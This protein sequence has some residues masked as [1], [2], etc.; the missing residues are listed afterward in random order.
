MRAI[1]RSI[2]KIF[3][4]ILTI[5]TVIITALSLSSCKTLGE[6]VIASSDTFE[7]TR[8]DII[9][10][11]STSG[12][13]D[14]SEKNDYSIAT[15]GKVLHALEKG[16]IFNKGDVLLEI[17]NS[18]QKL[19]IAQAEENL[20]AARNSFS[21]AQI[22]YQRALDANHIAIQLAET[23]SQQA[24]L[25]TISALKALEN[26]NNM[27]DKSEKSAKVAL[28]NAKKLLNE[29]KDEPL[30][31]DT[32]LAQYEANVD[33]AEANYDSV[34]AQGRSTAESAKNAYEQSILGQSA[35]YWSNL[36]STQS[37]KSQVEAT[38]VNIK[39]AETQINLSEISLE[40]ARLDVD[41]NIIYAPYNGIVLSS[42]YKEGQYASP[43]MNAISIISNDFIIKADINEADIVNLKVGQDVDIILDAYP[44]I[45]FKGKIIE[46]SRIPTSIGGVVSFDF[47]VRP[48]KENA[49]E[50]LYGLSASLE[51]IELVSENI[52]YVP[53]DSIIEEDG[54]TYVNLVTEDGKVKKTEVVTGAFNYEFI[55]IKSGLSEG[56]TVL[57][58]SINYGELIKES[59]EPETD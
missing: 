18:R 31:P 5:I 51:I 28:E 16:D 29:A 43:G 6:D 42:T 3:F 7:V 35:S 15:Q 17:D 44:E 56:D 48:D 23:S 32:Q 36:S 19:L 9:Q 46:I 57:I 14:S 24:E 54:K 33:S 10:T 2:R 50:L 53:I 40:L 20:E 58:S 47:L 37:A 22:N 45:K 4:L 12:Y 30:I 55:E 34:A 21:I 27:A 1:S 59:L 52:L 26:A 49:P 8:G 13:V 11:T 25:A 41:D 38:A 39:Q